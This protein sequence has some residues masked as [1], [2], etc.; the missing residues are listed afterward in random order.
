VKAPK[1]RRVEDPLAHGVLRRRVND[2]PQERE[3]PAFAVHG[4][5]PCRERNVPAV[6]AATLTDAEADQLQTG[7]R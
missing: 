5:R 3:A 6:P 2:G 1:V 4:V 7:E